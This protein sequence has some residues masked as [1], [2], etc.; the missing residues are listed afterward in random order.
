M[1][2]YSI[3]LMTRIFLY[4]LTH[5]I[6]ETARMFGI[7]PNTVFLLKKRF[8]ETGSLLPRKRVNKNEKTITPDGETYLEA[9]LSIEP[10]L[11]LGK[12]CELYE[13]TYGIKVS[14]STMFNTL[15]LL[16]YTRKKK[17]FSDPKKD[18]DGVAQLKKEYNVALDKIEPENRFYLDETGICLNMTLSYARSK[19][20]KSV[21][22]KKPTNKGKTINIITAL[23]KE[24]IQNKLTHTYSVPLTAELFISYLDTFVLPVLKTGQ[25]LIM[26]RHPVH[27]SKDVKEYLKQNKIQY[28]LLP[29][30]S[31]ELNPIEEAFSK[32]KQFIKTN[33]PRTV[34]KLLQ[35]IKDALNSIT[36]DDATGYF[37]HAAEF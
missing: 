5:S 31:P 33:K 20:G 10:D 18:E 23:S 8:I 35:V 29:P 34:E 7:S 25:T 9:V 2:A 22:E 36:Q 26:D 6:R 30:Y 19:K 27:C 37:Q 16:N 12:L 1:K 3:D 28:L 14:T 21:Y 24:G 13:E 4:Y 17:S 15:K 11:T 32:I